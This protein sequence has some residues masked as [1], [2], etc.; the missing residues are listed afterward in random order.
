MAAGQPMKDDLTAMAIQD[1]V[2]IPANPT[3]SLS[4][5]IEQ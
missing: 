2:S 4:G 1:G 3:S 5:L